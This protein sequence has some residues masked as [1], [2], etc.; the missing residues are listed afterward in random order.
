MFGLTAATFDNTYFFSKNLVVDTERIP[1]SKIRRWFTCADNGA[2][3]MPVGSIETGLVTA[4]S[5][6]LILNKTSA[7]TR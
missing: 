5:L 3:N 6:R 1:E 7:A 2:E 4:P